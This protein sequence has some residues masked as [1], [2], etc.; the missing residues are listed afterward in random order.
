MVIQIYKEIN[1]LNKGVEYHKSMW[2]QSFRKPA[3]NK[4][5]MKIKKYKKNMEDKFDHLIKLMNI[6][7][8]L[9]YKL[10]NKIESQGSSQRS[11]QESSD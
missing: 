2:F 9:D 11:S 5:L 6:Y 7:L 10:F 8:R 3:Y 4:N 1:G